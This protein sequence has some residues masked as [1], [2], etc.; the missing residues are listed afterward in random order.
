MSLYIEAK[1]L[2][3]LRR[4]YPQG[5]RIRLEHMEGEPQMPA[6]LK[7]CVSFVD[8]SGQIHVDWENGSSLALNRDV[9][10]FQKESGPE[11]C[12]HREAPSR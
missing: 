1:E 4:R 12:K 10:R 6:G 9:D 2:E 8:D 5:T 11:R 7:G 3:A